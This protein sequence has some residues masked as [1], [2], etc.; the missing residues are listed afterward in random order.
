M[1]RLH[2]HLKGQIHTLSFYLVEEGVLPLLGLRTCRQVELVSFSKAVHQLS[3]A[4]ADLSHE[5]QTEYRD[6]FSDNLGKL[7]VTYSMTIDPDV[8]RVVHPAH[9]I[10]VAMQDRVKAELESMQELGVII[11]V[12]EPPDWAMAATNKKDKRE[13]RIC[14][15]PR[16][17]NTALK[18][19][20]H[21]LC[22]V[23]EVA[24]HILQANVF[25][26]LGAESSF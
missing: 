18:R 13:R 17:L 19:Q 12:F 16:D 4:D 9:C 24:A 2:C 1:V 23:E 8:K 21:P 6:L 14:I 3:P 15:N 26:I 7:P 22:T 5:I 10:P 11:P 25:S 20:H